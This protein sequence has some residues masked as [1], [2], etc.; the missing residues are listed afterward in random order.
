VFPR[1]GGG[2]TRN[3]ETEVVHAK[4]EGGNTAGVTP[5]RFS[6]LSNITNTATMIKRE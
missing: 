6:N 5:G 3:H 2:E 1:G 4:I